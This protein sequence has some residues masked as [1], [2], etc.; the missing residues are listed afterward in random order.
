[1][2]KTHTKKKIR[3][4]VYSLNCRTAKGLPCSASSA[5]ATAGTLDTS[6][7]EVTDKG[8]VSG[9]TA[10]PSRT[11]GGVRNLAGLSLRAVRATTIVVVGRTG[12]KVGQH[13]GHGVLDPLLRGQTD[14]QTD[15]DER[16]VDESPTADG[17]LE[18]SQT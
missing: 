3:E 14:R 9:D 11:T 7:I 1:M 12:H 16:Q 13:G 4:N 18:S 15:R 10:W 5:A 8:N 2:K 17:S 6:N